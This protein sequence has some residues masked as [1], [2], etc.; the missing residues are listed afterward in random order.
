MEAVTEMGIDSMVRHTHI[1]ITVSNASL[2]CDR[3]PQRR[4]ILGSPSSSKSKWYRLV[5]TNTFNSF[6]TLPLPCR[7]D[8]IR[9]ILQHPIRKAKMKLSSSP[10]SGLLGW[11]LFGLHLVAV[12][13]LVLRGTH[14][15]FQ[16]RVLDHW[17]R[18]LPWALLL[19]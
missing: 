6:S 10:P 13:P 19:L 4:T 15:H 12:Q 1:S 3:T 16:P 8:P 2:Q 11:T 9:S 7:T 5:I 18:T 14:R 17:N